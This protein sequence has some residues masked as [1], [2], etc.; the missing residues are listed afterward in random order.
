MKVKVHSRRDLLPLFLI[1]F[2]CAG[3][4]IFLSYRPL[5]VF[6]EARKRGDPVALIPM[7]KDHLEL[8]EFINFRDPSVIFLPNQFTVGNPTVSV[9]LPLAPGMEPY[10]PSFYA[11][12]PWLDSRQSTDD[13]SAEIEAKALS[14]SLMRRPFS[15]FGKVP[16]HRLQKTELV[17]SMARI[18]AVG[19]RLPAK[20]IPLKTEFWVQ[21]GGELW[22]VAEFVFTLRDN[23]MAGPPSTSKS[24][25][26]EAVDDTLGRYLM[27]LEPLGLR[28]GY[29]RFVAGP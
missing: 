16:S 29:Y 11:R 6:R 20:I 7:A 14:M 23:A 8:M 9:G 22:G 28:D 4:W 13:N 10:P 24:S 27:E 15:T 25:G 5:E 12:D 26:S 1:F 21:Y 17:P 3:H 18:Y 2:V 19:E